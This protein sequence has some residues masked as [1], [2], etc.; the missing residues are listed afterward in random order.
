MGLSNSNAQLVRT[1][2]GRKT[3]QDSCIKAINLTEVSLS[4]KAFQHKLNFIIGGSPFIVT[5]TAVGNTALK[6]TG[7]A[8]LIRK[9]RS[10]KAEDKPWVRVY[11]GKF[12]DASG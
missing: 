7:S 5:E 9:R 12:G 8:A 2:K 11:R 3:Q 4:M 6:R 1:V 10:P